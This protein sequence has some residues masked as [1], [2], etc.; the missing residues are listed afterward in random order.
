MNIPLRN[1]ALAAAVAG[2]L[3]IGAAQAL[4]PSATINYTFYAAGGSA[5]EN[6][7]FWA[8]NQLL[9]PS[10]IDVYTT[11]SSGAADG[12]YLIVSGTTSAAGETALGITTP[13]NVLLFYYFKNGAYPNAVYPQA[14]PAGSA[15]SLLPFPTVASLQTA[16]AVAGTSSPAITPVSP[17]YKFT[18]VA[19][20]QSTDW[21]VGD[22][23]GTIFAYPDNQNGQ[24]GLTSTQLQSINQ[25]GI[26]VDVYGLA[27]TN[28]LYN[29]TAAFP[30]PKT[31]FT[32][33][34]A[35]GLLSGTVKNW[36]QLFADDGTQLPNKPV[37][38]LDR[39]SGSAT[40]AASNLYFLNYPTG[41]DTGGFTH[42]GS[43][44]GAGVNAGYTSTALNLA[45]GYQD[46][47]E[48]ANTTIV[49]DLRAVNAAGGYA[50]AILNAEFAP[51]LDPSAGGVPQY[52]FTKI[53]GNGLP[54][55]SG[56]QVLGIGIDSGVGA[57]NVNGTT[58]TQYSNVITGAYDFAYQGSFNTRSGFL[59]LTTANAKW[60][61]AI[62]T[63]FKSEAISGANTGLPFPQAVT[64]VLI[65]PANVASQDPGVIL[66]S[67]LRNS[68]API[69]L[70]F[71]A[72]TVNVIGSVQQVQLGADPL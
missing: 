42:A 2:V 40:K 64:G 18:P 51:A 12:S 35:Q 46:V 67:R 7:V 50:F 36:N 72:T 41:L 9:T 37:W 21:G 58:T 10:T 4:P 26:W 54:A 45:G 33:E 19:T 13:A 55:N 30:H 16:T 23:E 61:N 6:A 1:G 66:W 5:Q 57:D 17:T 24:P 15:Q 44:T 65:D 28:T 32:R 20:T 60:A 3:G 38:F 31:S 29:G 63:L 48:G 14:F 62:A 70:N 59:S 27:V 8:A 52:S 25:Q 43:V 56:K 71:D 47:K 69:Q 49:S 34:E 68:T 53:G 22:F 11:S 39:G